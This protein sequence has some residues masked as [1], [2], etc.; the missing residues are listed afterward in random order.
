ANFTPVPAGAVEVFVGQVEPL[1]RCIDLDH[2]AGVCGGLEDLVD[3]DVDAGAPADQP[4]RRVADD[5]DLPGRRRPL[6]G[7]GSYPAGTDRSGSGPT[8]RTGRTRRGTRAASPDH[9]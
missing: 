7:G 4:A 2:G 6:R 5:V 9:L 8:P 3:V 1:R